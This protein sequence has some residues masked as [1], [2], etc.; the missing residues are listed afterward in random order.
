MGCCSPLLLY[1]TTKISGI[2]DF[3]FLMKL[4]YHQALNSASFHMGYYPTPI[5]PNLITDSLCWKSQTQGFSRSKRILQSMGEIWITNRFKPLCFT[6]SN[7]KY[8]T[9]MIDEALLTDAS[10]L[11]KSMATPN[12]YRV[13]CVTGSL[14]S[15]KSKPQKHNNITSAQEQ[16]QFTLW[17]VFLSSNQSV[18][19]QKKYFIFIQL[20]EYYK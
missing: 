11:Q 10:S 3:F 4:S 15:L 13:P 19:P 14:S 12:S 17:R 20:Y 8:L 9:V 1:M 18:M 5:S 2:S 16:F 7:L 6:R